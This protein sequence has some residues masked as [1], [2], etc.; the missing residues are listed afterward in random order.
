MIR[1]QHHYL[2][3]VIS[4]EA[5]AAGADATRVLNMAKDRR[6]RA[7]RANAIN[8]VARETGAGPKA[9]SLAWGCC[10]ETV[11][12]VLGRKPP[13][14]KPAKTVNGYDERTMARLQWQY[15]PERAVAIVAGID[16][17]TNADLAA[18][19]ALGGAR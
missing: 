9:I 1:P 11:G 19:N 8:R 17:A 18:W 5:A 4:E 12:C 10:E 3:R 16:P 13:T 7:A 15:G 6:S 14:P 2:M